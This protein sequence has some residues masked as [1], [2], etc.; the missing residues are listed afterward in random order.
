MPAGRPYPALA[1][2][3]VEKKRAAIL[4]SRVAPVLIKRLIHN[5]F[6]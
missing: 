1:L 4:L 6:C 5:V 2:A 3:L